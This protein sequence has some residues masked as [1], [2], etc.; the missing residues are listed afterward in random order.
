MKVLLSFVKEPKP[1]ETMI[2][3]T[4]RNE[5]E[6]KQEHNGESNISTPIIDRNIEKTAILPSIKK[7]LVR[8]RILACDKDDRPFEYRSNYDTSAVTSPPN[9]HTTTTVS[10]DESLFSDVSPVTLD[11]ESVIRLHMIRV[12]G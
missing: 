3:K 10:K 11:F 6:Q 12:R 7:S 9:Y 1:R 2:E 8:S 5:I 4:L